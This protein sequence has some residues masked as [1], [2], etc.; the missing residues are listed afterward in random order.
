LYATLKRITLRLTALKQSSPDIRLFLAGQQNLRVD[1]FDVH[2][3]TFRCPHPVPVEA[4]IAAFLQSMPRSVRIMLGMREA[5]AKRIGLKTAAGKKS[6][7]HEVETFT[8]KVGEKIALF[9]VWQRN[10]QEIVTGQRD[11]HLDFALSFYLDRHGEEHHLKLITVVQLNNTLGRVYFAVVKPVH[12]IIMPVIT[13]RLA[14]RLL[15]QYQSL[16]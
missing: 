2:A 11:K 4:A 9:E 7:A 16:S 13:K 6:I 8:G 5:I 15:G 1:F 3:A 14:G 12:Q 10:E